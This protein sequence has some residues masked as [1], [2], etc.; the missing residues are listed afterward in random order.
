MSEYM[1]IMRICPRCHTFSV[2]ND[3]KCLNCKGVV[4]YTLISEY[5]FLDFARDVAFFTG[6]GIIGILLLFFILQAMGSG[7]I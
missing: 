2:T 6:C 3:N 4:T 7:G 5:K 1:Y